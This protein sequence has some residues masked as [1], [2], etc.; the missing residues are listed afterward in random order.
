ML[1]VVFIISLDTG[2]ILGFEIKCKHS[3][4]C[5][6]WRKW[7]E[8]GDKCKAGKVNENKCCINHEKSADK[9]RKRPQ[10]L[11]QK[12]KTKP[13]DKGNYLASYK[14]QCK[15]FSGNP[16]LDKNKTTKTNTN[17]VSSTCTTDSEVDVTFIDE[18]TLIFF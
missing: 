2:E 1:G 7:D 3:F 17:S 14:N 15:A 11:K 18:K 4:E 12:R 16:L 9:Y 13:A 10:N 6:V 5:R 8:N